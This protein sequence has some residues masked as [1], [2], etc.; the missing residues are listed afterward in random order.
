MSAYFNSSPARSSPSGSRSVRKSISSR[1]SISTIIPDDEREEDDDA[2]ED[3][4]SRRAPDQ[5]FDQDG[6]EYD[7]S[8]A[9]NNGDLPHLPDL[10]VF[11]QDYDPDEYDGP[12][13]FG[14]GGED[15]SDQ[16]HEVEQEFEYSDMQVDDGKI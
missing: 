5:S 8:M 14:G 4:R 16:E 13:D 11:R 12:T 10:P 7:D 15:Y 3:D 1:K 6:Q 9:E 2:F